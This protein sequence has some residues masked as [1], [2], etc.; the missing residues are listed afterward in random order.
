MIYKPLVSFS[1][2]KSLVWLQNNLKILDRG[3]FEILQ[4][5]R[6]LLA[7]RGI[8]SDLRTR[9][10]SLRKI[11]GGWWFWLYGCI[12]VS[13]SVSMYKSFISRIFWILRRRVGSKKPKKQPKSYRILAN[14]TCIFPFFWGFGLR[15]PQG[16]ANQIWSKCYPPKWNSK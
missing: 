15:N 4:W 14:Q 10:S 9:I 11:N 1:I 6:L 3:E 16:K 2:L 7:D 12:S 8:I 5:E 13:D